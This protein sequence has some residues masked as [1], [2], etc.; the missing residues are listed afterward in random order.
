MYRYSSLLQQQE[1]TN[2]SFKD[3]PN[4]SSSSD[5]DYKT[6]VINNSSAHQ[7]PSLEL[8]FSLSETYVYTSDNYSIGA[9]AFIPSLSFISFMKRQ[10]LFE[11]PRGN[12]TS[13]IEGNYTQP[14][15]RVGFGVPEASAANYDKLKNNSQSGAYGGVIDDLRYGVGAIRSKSYSLWLD[16][17]EDHSG[18]LLLGG[19]DTDAYTGPLTSLPTTIYTEETWIWSL[20]VLTVN[21]SFTSVTTSGQNQSLNLSLPV[22]ITALTTNPNTSLPPFVA[23]AI[24]DALGADYKPDGIDVGYSELAQLVVASPRVPC[25][26]LTNSSTLD[27]QFTGSNITVSVPMSDITI[28]RT[29]PGDDGDFEYCRLTIMASWGPGPSFLGADML[30]NVY[31]VYDLDNNVVSV[32]LTNFTSAGRNIVP[33]PEEGGVAAMNLSIS[34]SSDLTSGSH[35]V[36]GLFDNI[37]IFGIPVAVIVLGAAIF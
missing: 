4:L 13:I 32:A 21:T 29:R 18:H 3:N 36:V 7:L 34:G 1:I 25:S 28:K 26:Y 22:G 20:P 6:I 24:W 2:S 15:H 12:E 33:I 14:W 16:A 37:L 8:G 27:F 17:P 30:K 5:K 19:L 9:L 10:I 11:L 23:K 35:G 31:Q